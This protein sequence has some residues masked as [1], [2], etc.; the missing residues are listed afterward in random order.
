MKIWLDSGARRRSRIN[1][2]RWQT[3]DW[4]TQDDYTF[5]GY[6]TFGDAAAVALW[7]KGASC[8]KD[9][10]NVVGQ[11]ALA[12]ME[13][14]GDAHFASDGDT[15]LRLDNGTLSLIISLQTYGSNEDQEWP[16]HDVYQATMKN[17]ASCA[18]EKIELLDTSI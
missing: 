5:A 12:E 15:E 9:V 11:K 4:R 16:I 13:S 8:D 2:G 3:L 7:T 18:V 10:T 1:S 14:N 6:W 17:A